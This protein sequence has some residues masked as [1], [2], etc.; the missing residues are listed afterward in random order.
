MLDSGAEPHNQKMELSSIGLTLKV[1]IA[2]ADGLTETTQLR[3]F[4]EG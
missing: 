1:N 3:T 2:I 4:P